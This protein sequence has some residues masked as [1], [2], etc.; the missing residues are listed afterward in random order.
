MSQLQTFEPIKT[1]MLFFWVRESKL[2]CFKQVHS[3][4]SVN[5]QE[6]SPKKAK[7]IVELFLCNCNHYQKPMLLLNCVY[8]IAMIMK[9]KAVF[10]NKRKPKL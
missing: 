10:P 9:A 3:E 2:K 5:L 6:N 1:K 7:H 8:A 4:F